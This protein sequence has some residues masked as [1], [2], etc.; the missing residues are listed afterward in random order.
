LAGP[1][2]KKENSWLLLGFAY[3]RLEQYEDA[4][5]S[6]D[7][8]IEIDPNRVDLWQHKAYTLTN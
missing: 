4:L 2:D 6:F 8:A 3:N 5:Q 7:K 1:G